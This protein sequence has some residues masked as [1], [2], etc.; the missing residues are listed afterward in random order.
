MKNFFTL[1]LLAGS[2]A[3]FAQT[4]ITITVAQFPATAAS[5][6]RLQSAAVAGVTAPLTGANRSWDYRNLT[7]FGAVRVNTYTSAGA[8]PPFAGSV[9]AY[10]LSL[11]QGPFSA[12][13][14]G[15]EGF[16]AQGFSQLGITVAAQSFPLATITGGPG[17]VL[18]IPAQTTAVNNLR[19]PLPLTSTSRVVRTTRVANI[20]SLTVLLLGLNQAS[21]RY[22]QRT[23]T[24]D[25]VAGWGTVRIPVA[26]SSVGSGAIPSL[27]VQ[28]RVVSQD[29]F[30]LNNQPAPAFLLAALGQ[31]QGANT[32]EYTHYFF[33]QN[34]AQPVLILNYAN[35]SFTSPNGVSYS[36]EPSIP[37]TAATAREV[38]AGGLTAWPNPV[39]QG[40]TLS[41]SLATVA[42]AQ[43]LRLTL[44]D[45]LGRVVVNALAP[46]GQPASL[47]TLPAGLYLAEAE[48]AN[49]A[50]ASRRVVVE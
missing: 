19:V 44:R 15:Y 2:T 26:G 32:L 1:C 20:S 7:P 11:S 36:A 33:R 46:N 47:P 12:V 28:R 25:S 6:D 16:D 35:N 3:A 31:T 30:Y 9:R 18:A 21:F 48:A 49:G 40:Q 29:S 45:A 41:F 10:P 42:A 4:P 24:V 38:A 23:T 39:A 17:D 27:L 50:H 13:A 37:L 34:A 8:T 22:V 14:T 43:P 5:V